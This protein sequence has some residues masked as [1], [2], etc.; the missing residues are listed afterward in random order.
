MADIYVRP[1]GEP[2]RNPLRFLLPVLLIAA[3]VGGGIWWW[4]EHSTSKEKEPEPAAAT[5]TVDEPEESPSSVSPPPARTPSNSGAL[6]SNSGAVSSDSGAASSAP[7]ASSAEARRLFD[8]AKA[9][10]AAGKL[11]YAAT[12]LEKVVAQSADS[13]LAGNAAR[14]LGQLNMKLLF[15]ESPSEFK[16][17]YVVQSGDSLDRIA[18][19]NNTTVELLRKMNGIDGDLIYPGARLFF[20]AAPFEVH[21][22]KSDRVL[23]LMMNGK[24]FK[25]YLVG[26]GR[27]GKTPTGTFHTVVHQTNPDWSSPSGGIIKYGDPLNVLGTRWMSFEDKARP[28]LRGFGI[29]GT[30]DPSSIGGETSNGCIRMRNEDVEQVFMLIPRGT[31]VVIQE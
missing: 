6:P 14:E 28:D 4:L 11:S 20:Q 22:D 9:Q 1:Y 25:R 12:L 31:K 8:E 27:G 10:A 23:D 3:V 29:H 16:K 18:R 24:L 21:V 17:S 30:A 19:N 7:R 15:S 2:S 13:T 5:Q 26:V